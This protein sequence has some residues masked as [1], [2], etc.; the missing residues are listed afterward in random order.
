MNTEVIKEIANQLGIAVSAV[1]KDVIPAYAS[2]IIAAHISKAIIFVVLAIALLI[3]ARFCMIKSKEYANWEQEKL[4]K[5]QRSDMKDKYET[6]EA[7][8]YVC[9]VLGA[10]FAGIIVRALALIIPW[11]TSPYGAFIH[12]LMPH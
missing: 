4:T 2:Y 12:L 6:L 11:I 7:I 3:I 5:Y 1:T 9:Y 8:S 10:L